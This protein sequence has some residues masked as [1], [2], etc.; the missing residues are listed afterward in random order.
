MF[1]LSVP[2]GPISD[3][4]DVIV[5]GSKLDIVE[6]LLDAG[7]TNVV[8]ACSGDALVHA[9]QAARRSH[10]VVLVDARED[11]KLPTP[12]TKLPWTLGH[13]PM[14]VWGATCGLARTVATEGG[15]PRLWCSRLLGPRAIAAITAARR[16][17]D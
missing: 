8:L 15:A 11:G 16:G 3:A 4:P 17:G 10:A 2:G 1:A 14:L 12:L 13:L 6:A 9:M 7:L 5:A